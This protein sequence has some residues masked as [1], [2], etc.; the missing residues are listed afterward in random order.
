MFLPAPLLSF[1]SPFFSSTGTLPF[2]RCIYNNHA[3]NYIVVI[4]LIILMWISEIVHF[5]QL[6][7]VKSHSTQT[8]LGSM[9]LDK[10][11]VSRARAGSLLRPRAHGCRH[12]G[13]RLRRHR[14]IFHSRGLQG[15]EVRTTDS[16][17][18]VFQT[19]RC[20]IRI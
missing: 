17:K 10:S 5:K 2:R 13:Q 16:P 3:D 6:L 11:G 12:H 7:T 15:A 9:S 1:S 4:T 20:Q 19:N 18:R 8:H 14:Q